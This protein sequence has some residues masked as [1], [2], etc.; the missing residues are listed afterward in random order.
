MKMVNK[1]FQKLYKI[2]KMEEA[3]DFTLDLGFSVQAPPELSRALMEPVTGKEVFE[4]LHCLK[5]M[6]A[7]GLDGLHL[8]FFQRNWNIGGQS[9]IEFSERGQ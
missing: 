7:P 9:L 4:A 1:S 2:E 6:K 3:R 8:V 5:P